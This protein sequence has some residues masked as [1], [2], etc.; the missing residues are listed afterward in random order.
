MKEKDDDLGPAASSGLGLQPKRKASCAEAGMRRSSKRICQKNAN[1]PR[2]PK[3]LDEI[4]AGTFILENIMGFLDTRTLK[5]CRTVSKN[6]EETARKVLMERSFLNIARWT[7]SHKS[8]M[9]QYPNWIVDF[10]IAE[11]TSSAGV[12]NHLRKWGES[13]KSLYIT[14]VETQ[15]KPLAEES[16]LVL[17]PWVAS[18]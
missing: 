3:S 10:G 11:K 13:V 5:I 17:V 14:G 6:W 15:T 9:R 12:S 8:R 16:V 1:E 2:A 18:K 7:G 4:C